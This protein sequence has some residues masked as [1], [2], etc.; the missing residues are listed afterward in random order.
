MLWRFAIPTI[1]SS[2][3]LWAAPATAGIQ[4]Y[5][6]SQG[7]IRISNGQAAPADQGRPKGPGTA[8][9][10]GGPGDSEPRQAAALEPNPPGPQPTA[11]ALQ[12]SP[13]ATNPDPVREQKLPARREDRG[14]VASP[15]PSAQAGPMPLKKVAFT[16]VEAGPAASPETRMEAPQKA[17]GVSQGGIRR[18]RDRQ[19]VL[20][21]T[22]AAPGREDSGPRLLPAKNRGESGEDF[23]PARPGQAGAVPGPWPLQKVSWSPDNPGDA[24]LPALAAAAGNTSSAP[25]NIRCYRDRQGV[26]HIS[27]GESGALAAVHPPKPQ[28]RAGPGGEESAAPGEIKPSPWDGAEEQGA[29]KPGPQA[30]ARVPHP[31]TALLAAPFWQPGIAPLGGI[32]RY[33]DSRGV[34]HLETANGPGLAGAPQLPRLSELGRKL[35]LAGINPAAAPPG[36]AGTPA[37]VQTAPALGR[38]CGGVTV[39]RDKKGRLTITNTQ[40]VAEMGKFLQ[41]AEA[42]AW[43][44]PIIQEAA[45]VYRLPD[46]L[47][48]AVIK[49]ESNFATWAVSPKGAMGLMQ[50]MPGTAAFLGVQDPFNPREN[51]LGG[52]RYLRLLIDF[53]GGSLQLALAGYN[54]GYQRVVDCGYRVPEIKETQDFLT[55]VMG[56]YLAEER[57]VLLPRI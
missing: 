55:Q 26:L 15:E 16:G 28:A 3:M 46:N 32:R 36:S 40:P 38:S 1:L 35:T 53:F 30:G 48:R 42:R 19:G 50:L 23:L 34:S 2:W 18:F 44:E 7:V 51:I 37:A 22:N 56:R 33:R 21:I 31:P 45:R 52:C 13:Q 5:V 14:I 9:T 25:G 49:V 29:H 11:P 10:Q 27:N 41:T 54:A 8:T 57:K 4:R 17:D 39:S 20:H 6:D 12:N 47:I 24:A 43:L